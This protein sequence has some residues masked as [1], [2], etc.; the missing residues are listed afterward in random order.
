MTTKD[1]EKEKLESIISQLNK[2]QI[3]DSLHLDAPPSFTLDEY[4]LLADMLLKSLDIWL[5]DDLDK[6]EITAIEEK[7]EVYLPGGIDPVHFICDLEAKEKETGKKIIIDWKTTSSELDT[8]WEERKRN[9]WQGKTY[10]ATLGYDEMHYRG[11][12]T[13]L[14]TRTVEIKRYE[15]LQTDVEQIYSQVG[16][17]RASLIGSFPWPRNMPQSCF[18][19]GRNCEYKT[20]CIKNTYPKDILIPKSISPSALDNFLLCPERHR[21]DELIKLQERAA[22]EVGQ[23]IVTEGESYTSSYNRDIGAAFHRGAAE[24]YRQV[25]KLNV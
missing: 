14:K 22:K 19:F 12:S 8:R 4:D 15:S 21:R 3:N 16:T 10:I 17:M 7:K 18:A 24:I 6:Y 5:L 13:R 11:V 20:D 23:V 9:S 1:K 2:Q 25:F